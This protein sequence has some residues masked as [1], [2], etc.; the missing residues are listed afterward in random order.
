MLTPRRGGGNICVCGTLG[1]RACMDSVVAARSAK[2][3][4]M[5]PSPACYNARNCN[6]PLA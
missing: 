3:R 6:E 4:V 1:S 2:K 5:T